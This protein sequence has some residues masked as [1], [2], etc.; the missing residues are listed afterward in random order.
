MLDNE[1]KLLKLIEEKVMM[2]RNEVNREQLTRV[3]AIENIQ[4]CL[5]VI[6]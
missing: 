2:L 6:I 5:T 1:N 3:D 4:T